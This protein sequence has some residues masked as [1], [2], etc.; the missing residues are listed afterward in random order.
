MTTVYIWDPQLERP[1][2]PMG[3]ASI[4][5]SMP[6]RY[7]SFYPRQS[8]STVEKILGTPADVIDNYYDDKKR[9]GRPASHCIEIEALDEERMASKWQQIQDYA[10]WELGDYQLVKRNCSTLVGNI[11]LAGYRGA[12]RRSLV[13][14]EDIA[15]T[16]RLLF[17]GT[18]RL[19]GWKD[20][21]GNLAYFTPASVKDLAI[22]LRKVVCEDSL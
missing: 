8:S 13:D 5:F 7:I 16:L 1:K 12:M 15:E 10:W 3:H 9:M 4:E 19:I 22:R 17:F 14:E 6:Y 11:L 2:S 21:I 18:V 20:T